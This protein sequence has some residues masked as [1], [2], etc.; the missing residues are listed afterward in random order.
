ML[1]SFFQMGQKQHYIKDMNHTIL[2]FFISFALLITA[3]FSAG[4]LYAQSIFD[5][6]IVFFKRIGDLHMQ[7]QTQQIPLENSENVYQLS[8]RSNSEGLLPQGYQLLKR[9]EQKLEGVY[10]RLRT[11]PT[12]RP[13]LHIGWRQTLEDKDIT[14]WL[15]FNI[16]DQPMQQG[17]TDFQGILRFSRNQGLL[18]ETQVIGYRK[19]SQPPETLPSA[20]QLSDANQESAELLIGSDVDSEK[21]D[22]AID[23]LNLSSLEQQNDVLDSNSLDEDMQVPDELSGYFEMSETLKV[24]L[25]ELYYVDHPTMGLLIKVTPYQAA[26][27]QQEL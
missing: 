2:K 17:L 25:G 3:L 18:I 11:S 12:I 26:S 24:K 21:S 1:N 14:P 7:G 19:P 23:S 6:E 10:N 15:N 27:E 16:Q 22:G 5:V 13:L 4:K 8:E 9:S 20:S